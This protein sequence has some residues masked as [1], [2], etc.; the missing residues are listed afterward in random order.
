MRSTIKCLKNNFD[1]RYVR[2]IGTDMRDMQHNFNSLDEF[3]KVPRCDSPDY[4]DAVIKLCKSRNVDVLI[5]TNTIELEWF[6]S[7]RDEIESYG[8]A[9][10]SAGKGISLINSKDR[11]DKCINSIGLDNVP[12]ALV[13]DFEQAQKFITRNGLDK[14]YCIKKLF[15]C[16]ARG[17]RVITACSPSSPIDKGENRLPISALEEYLRSNGPMLMQEYLEGD[18][19]TV[20]ML[21]D[22]GETLYAI[23]KVNSSMCNGVAQKSVVVRNEYAVDICKKIA[24]KASL[25]G[26][27]GFDLRYSSSGSLYVIDANPRLTATVSLSYYVG[28]NLP[29]LG[30]KYAI[31]EEL[32]KLQQQSYNAVCI[33]RTDDY[34]FVG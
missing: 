6:E 7:R 19:L 12:S 2:V 34:F 16:G 15:D 20:D 4:V 32:P 3:H 23:V 1:R 11:L 9:L 22:K 17:F 30:L 21:C 25:S 26:N 8:I 29:Y 24:K 18:E 28:I 5:P 33:R 27:V 13:D 31:G 10:A 14:L